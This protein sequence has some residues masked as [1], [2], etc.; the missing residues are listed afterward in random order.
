MTI[1]TEIRVQVEGQ[2]SLLELEPVR[3][4]HTLCQGMA[5]QWNHRWIS[6]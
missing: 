5:D 3:E 4:F 1:K 6:K 2:K